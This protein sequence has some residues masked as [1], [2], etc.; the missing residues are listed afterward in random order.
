MNKSIIFVPAGHNIGI[1]HKAEWLLQSKSRWLTQNWAYLQTIFA[2][3]WLNK[4]LLSWFHYTLQACMHVTVWLTVPPSH[5][6]SIC[7]HHAYLSIC[8]SFW[9]CCVYISRGAICYKV[10]VS[11]RRVKHGKGHAGGELSDGCP[12]LTGPRGSC[13]ACQSPWGKKEE[14]RGLR[15]TCTM[16]SWPHPWLPCQQS[17]V[18]C[19]L[20]V[21]PFFFPGTSS[22]MLVASTLNPQAYL[23]TII[24]WSD[25]E[26]HPDKKVCQIFL[27]SLG[28]VFVLW[29]INTGIKEMGMTYVGFDQ[30]R[31]RSWLVGHQDTPVRHILDIKTYIY[32]LLHIIFWLYYWLFIFP[33]KR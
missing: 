9:L 12:P 19:C 30:H 13:V 1:A 8:V 20:L 29:T 4:L 18:G 23:L 3:K 21:F 24:I 32:S 7:L 28:L 33:F 25:A 14:E 5:F 22:D 26:S 2:T 6:L 10:I 16:L 17:W 27:S 11:C 15:S 31:C